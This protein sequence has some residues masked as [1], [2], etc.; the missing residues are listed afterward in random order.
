MLFIFDWDGTLSDST[1]RIVQCM[2][3]AAEA[4]HIQSPTTDQIRNIIGLGLNEALK[5]LYPSHGASQHA[6]LR[7][8]YSQHYVLADQRPCDFFDGALELLADLRAQG[9]LLA[10][11]TGKS[12][13]GL[14]RVL[15]ALAMDNFFHAT[16]CADETCS[17]P[18]PMMIDEL[19]Q[20][21]S[22]APDQAVVIGDTEYDLEMASRAGVRSV[23]VSYGVHSSERLARHKPLAIIDQILELRSVPGL[24]N[25]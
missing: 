11:A 2:Q 12:R 24:E 19:L 25:S 18:D 7:D 17:K 5:L 6:L 21:L 14:D 13:R 4:N 10:V 8:T 3:S 15:S 9:H 20:E 16:R 22:V 23:G 1:E